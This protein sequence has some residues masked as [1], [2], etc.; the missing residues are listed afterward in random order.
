MALYLLLALLPPGPG[1]ASACSSCGRH[2]LN[3]EPLWWG[4]GAGMGPAERPEGCGAVL[5]WLCDAVLW[6][7]QREI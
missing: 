1:V 6:S 4:C 5:L 7:G 2:V 3:G